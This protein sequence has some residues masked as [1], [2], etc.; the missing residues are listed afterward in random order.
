M[1]LG[2]YLNTKDFFELDEFRKCLYAIF[3]F[4][5]FKYITEKE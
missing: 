2:H 5:H 3:D 4:S 1:L